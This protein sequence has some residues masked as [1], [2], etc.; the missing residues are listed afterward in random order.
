MNSDRSEMMPP[1]AS[2]GLGQA[3]PRAQAAARS[4]QQ[5]PYVRQAS[6]HQQLPSDFSP[7]WPTHEPNASAL[8]NG[9]REASP[10]RDDPL[11]SPAP[12]ATMNATTHAIVETPLGMF[13]PGL[14][15]PAA[16]AAQLV[17]C[18]PWGRMDNAWL[19]EYSTV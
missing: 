7:Q 11:S 5:S 6:S 18:R 3:A 9:P 16:Y 4:K 1:N 12:Q 19:V 14:I 10:E 8:P 2:S 15:T 13:M 17:L